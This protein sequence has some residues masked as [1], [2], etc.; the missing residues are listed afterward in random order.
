VLFSPVNAATVRVL[1]AEGFDVVIPRQQGCCG[2]LSAHAGRDEEAQGFARSLIETFDRTG[3]SAVIVN[4][5]GCGSAMKEYAH[6]LR[7][8]PLYAHVAEQ[9]SSRVRDV[10]EFL[11]EW[12]PR[13]PRHALE[14]T[15]AYHDACHL[16]HAQG[17]RTQPRDLLQAIPGLDLREVAEGEICCGSAGIYNLLQPE[18][19]GE[20]GDRKA[21][22]VLASGA[23]L[24]VAANPG[25]TMQVTA[26]LRRVGTRLPVAHTIEVIDASIS[27]LPARTLLGR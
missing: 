7:D 10:A 3:V 9:F 5:A 27:G 13:A 16:A 14:V 26:A 15:V 18:A 4:S 6:L 23:E 20:L 8:D 11:A 2:A 24:L 12:E 19:G 1:V 21:R 17:V 22:N 25:C